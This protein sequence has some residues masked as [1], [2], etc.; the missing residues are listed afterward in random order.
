M[1]VWWTNR[2]RPPLSEAMNP[3]PFSS[4]NHL[5]VPVGMQRFLLRSCAAP[6]EEVLCVPRG[7]HLLRRH[8]K[9]PL[10]AETVPRSATGTRDGGRG[11]H[12]YRH[13]RRDGPWPR[14]E[15][16]AE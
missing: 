9:A 5:T 16:A 7:L 2:S 10:T 13:G 11:V 12:P 1:L 3:K 6:P 15:G 8:R 14:R 4:L